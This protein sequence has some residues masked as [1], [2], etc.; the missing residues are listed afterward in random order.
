MI[1]FVLPYENSRTRGRLHVRPSFDERSVVLHVTGRDPW[2][3]L[4]AA[5]TVEDATLIRDALTAVI[6][7]ARP[8]VAPPLP[9]MWLGAE[10]FEQEAA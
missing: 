2:V 6:D 1:N 5:F 4:G 8:P 9:A 3:L 7:A 10:A